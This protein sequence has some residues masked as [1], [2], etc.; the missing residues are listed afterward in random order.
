M[1][2]VRTQEDEPRQRRR[3]HPPA[4]AND[5]CLTIE[6]N[7]QRT[8]IMHIVRYSYPTARNLAPAFSTFGR[9]AW[10]G[11]ENE[12]NQL[13]EST[14][15]AVAGRI[16]VD[17]SEDKDNTYVRAELPGVAREDVSLELADGALTI[18][19]VR[20]QKTGETEQ[21]FTANR[22]IGLPE[23]IDVEKVAA[24]YENGVLTVTLPKAEAAKPRKITLS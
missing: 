17:V 8:S 3:L 12:L 23:S 18:A 2:K 5:E 7:L 24:K 10:T 6:N 14:T 13:F 1:S 9:N 16:P 4:A 20:K 11:L 22:T 19:A 15:A 21:S